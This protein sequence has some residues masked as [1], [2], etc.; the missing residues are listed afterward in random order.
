[1]IIVC[2]VGILGEFL[3]GRRILRVED[4][5]ASPLKASEAVYQNQ[6]DDVSMENKEEEDRHFG[7]LL[8]SLGATNVFEE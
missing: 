1:M 6:W 3:R 5:A 2:I 4:Q 7:M 8:E